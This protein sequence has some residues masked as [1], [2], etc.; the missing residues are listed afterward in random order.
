GKKLLTPVRRYEIFWWCSGLGSRTKQPPKFRS[1]PGHIRQYRTLIRNVPGL[2]IERTIQLHSSICAPVYLK[3]ST[4]KL[5]YH[6]SSSSSK[7][8][9]LIGK[10][11]CSTSSLICSRY[12]I[13]NR[14]ES[15]GTV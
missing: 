1:T 12:R 8:S 2:N 14:N 5:H 7:G 9:K 15:V 6:V 4:Y 10:L 3:P 11:C 13:P